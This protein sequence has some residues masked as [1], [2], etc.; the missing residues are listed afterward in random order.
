MDCFEHACAAERLADAGRCTIT[1][2]DLHACS[3]SAVRSEY[4]EDATFWLAES[5]CVLLAGWQ[6]QGWAPSC[7]CKRIA[8]WYAALLECRPPCPAPAH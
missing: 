2:R 3:P 1:S 5:I 6:K 8:T 4:G 7:A